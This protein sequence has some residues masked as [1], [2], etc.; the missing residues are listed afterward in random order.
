MGE[1][2]IYNKRRVKLFWD[3]V[4]D[5]LYILSVILILAQSY[6]M[7]KVYKNPCYYCYVD[8]GIVRGRVSEIYQNSGNILALNIS[9]YDLKNESKKT[10]KRCDGYG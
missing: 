8:D 6:Y 5:L 10:E 7:Y 1:K 3:R 9:I 4:V 2:S